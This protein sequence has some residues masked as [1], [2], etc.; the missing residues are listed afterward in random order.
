MQI[1]YIALIAAAL[2]MLCSVGV[3]ASLEI[4]LSPLSEVNAKLEQTQSLIK[5]LRFKLALKISKRVISEL[6]LGA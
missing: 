1:K 5:Q 3:Q 4:R 6:N 2:M